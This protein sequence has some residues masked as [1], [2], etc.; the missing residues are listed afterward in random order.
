M[1][2]LQQCWNK[3]ALQAISQLLQNNLLKIHWK[4]MKATL[5]LFFLFFWRTVLLCANKDIEHNSAPMLMKDLP[6]S[7][8]VSTC[9]LIRVVSADTKEFWKTFITNL[10]WFKIKIELSEN[11]VPNSE[12][13]AQI[14]FCLHLSR[15]SYHARV[16]LQ[17]S[18][19]TS[20]LILVKNAHQTELIS[21]MVPSPLQMFPA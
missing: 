11:V 5:S 4:E 13:V 15:P 18:R 16:A 7:S 19:R 20:L 9:T 12:S 8:D 2:A 6:G 17:K 1:L 21:F 14:H 3:E 10:N